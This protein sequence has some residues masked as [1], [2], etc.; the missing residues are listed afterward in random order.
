MK[1]FYLKLM[2]TL[3]MA[4]VG[5]ELLILGLLWA[6]MLK[7]MKLDDSES[8]EDEKPMVPNKWHLNNQIHNV[9]RFF[10]RPLK[11]GSIIK[12]MGMELKSV[13]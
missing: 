10:R 11:C 8:A 4:H 3:T 7:F 13:T 2:A 6:I 9:N 1:V 12:Y 5:N